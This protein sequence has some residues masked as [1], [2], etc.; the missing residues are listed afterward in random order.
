MLVKNVVTNDPRVLGEARALRQGGHDVF[1]I[2]RL[3]KGYA[4][5]E[6]LDGISIL[7]LRSTSR[8]RGRR[9][10][11]SIMELNLANGGEFCARRALKRLLDMSGCVFRQLT[12]PFRRNW[13]RRLWIKAAVGLKC[14]VY[15]AHDLNTLDEAAAAARKHGA[16]LVY[17]SHELWLEWQENKIGA[18][19]LQ[20]RR[21]SRVE[22]KWAHRADLVIT[23]S[24]GI[25]K[26]LRRL[27]ALRETPLVVYNCSDRRPLEKSDWLRHVVKQERSRCIILYQGGVSEGR[28]LDTF[29]ELA[30]RLPQ[31]D[32]VVIGPV[33]SASY[34]EK[35]RRLVNGLKN[36]YIVDPVPY[37]QLYKVTA[38][39]DIGYV[40][41]EPVCESYDL[42]LSNKIF[43]YLAS[44][45]P[46]IASDVAGHRELMRKIPL[47]VSPI[48]VVPLSD[49]EESVR[50]IS[51]LV[52]DEDLR[53]KMATAA[54]RS[55]ETEFN[56]DDQMSKLVDAYASMDDSP[57][58]RANS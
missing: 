23:V 12:G 24:D 54:R 22:R 37:K 48:I 26:K 51:A 55:V 41:T 45:L 28:G 40:C 46:V 42:T 47:E 39:A 15:H 49:P 52:L 31:A 18:S 56:R 14:D 10:S 33:T 4:P 34:V 53:K 8:A 30:K 13:V 57:R 27:Y 16:R 5:S 6:D 29:V 36:F 58:L 43:E 38:S 1:V 21:W 2:G 9:A 3:E 35:L 32:F 11:C 50:R 44:G 17:D 7:R 19:H 20:L 25:A